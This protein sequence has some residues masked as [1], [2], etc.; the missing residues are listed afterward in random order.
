MIYTVYI[1]ASPFPRRGNSIRHVNPPI[2]QAMRERERDEPH[3][4][5]SKVKRKA[6]KY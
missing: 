1:R 3:H 2:T 4:L 6:W 5:A